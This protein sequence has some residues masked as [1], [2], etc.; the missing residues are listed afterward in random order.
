[1][2]QMLLCFACDV[3]LLVLRAD[4][5]LVCIWLCKN[6]KEMANCWTVRRNCFKA[7]TCTECNFCLFAECWG[8]ISTLKE[9]GGFWWNLVLGESALKFVKQI[10]FGLF[11]KTS[12][13]HFLFKLN[14]FDTG[15]PDWGFLFF[16]QTL[17][18]QCPRPF[19]YGSII[20]L[21]WLQLLVYQLL[22]SRYT[23]EFAAN[24]G[25][26]TVWSLSPHCVKSFMCEK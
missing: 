11:T 14:V 16:H 19:T 22:F 9:L 23:T 6:R 25:F 2:T 5:L 17:L 24:S 4:M 3:F 26:H 1:M 7:F 15:N 18:G 20:Q 13:L 21:L 10:Y 12:L 8:H